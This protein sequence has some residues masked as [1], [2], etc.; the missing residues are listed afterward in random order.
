MDNPGI[1]AV[2]GFP[3]LRSARNITITRNNALGSISGLNSLQTANRI[4]ITQCRSLNSI[5]GFANLTSLVPAS[6]Q[7]PAALNITGNLALQTIPSFP[8]LSSLETISIMYNDALQQVTG[9]NSLRNGRSVY[10]GNNAALTT[11]SGFNGGV[12]LTS[13]ANITTNQLL[14]SITGFNG[15]RG[16]QECSVHHNP[17]LLDIAGFNNGAMTNAVV[18]TNNALTSVTGFR[19][20]D[21][22]GYIQVA[23]NPQLDTL[24]GFTGPRAPVGIYL[25]A[26]PRLYDFS[27]A[28]SF[29]SYSLLSNLTIQNNT[30]LAACAQP[31]ICAYLRRGGG[32]SISGNAPA[33]TQPAILQACQSHLVVSTGTAANPTVVPAGTYSSLTVT[34]TGYGVLAGDV[35]VSGPVVVQSGGGLSDGCHLL[36]GTGAFTLA[37]GGT[38]GICSPAGI[39]ASGATG[40]VQLTGI[41]SFSTDANY[42]YNG[43]TT[44]VTGSGL[45]GQVRSLSTTNANA[46][47]LTSP[48]AVSQIVGVGGAGNLVLNSNGL[49]LL[50]SGSGTALV[51]NSS[52]GVVSGTTATMQRHIETNTAGTG[53][54]HYSSPVQNESLGT[55]ATA[56]YAPNFSGAA[57]YNSSPT[58]GLVTP[59]PTV[60]QYDQ[61]RIATTAS[62]FSPFD[63]GYEAIASGSGA[64]EVG[65][66][67]AVNAPGAALVDFTGTL[68]TGNVTRSSLNR[69]GADG[70]WHL[71]GNPYPAPLDWSTLTLGAGQNLE[72]L[73]GAV[74]V[75]QSSGPYAGT[76][77]TY[78]AGAPGNGSPLIPAGAGF[79]VHTTAP[80]TPGT[81]RLTNANRVTAF[82]T[83]PAFGRG[84]ADARPQLAL[85][86]SN[87]ANTL[88]DE[89]TLYAEAR[90]TAGVEAA[91]DARKLANPSGLGL[92]LLTPA[93][94]AL[95]VDGRAALAAG[96]VVPL[97]VDVPAAG[98][99]TLRTTLANLPAGLTAYLRDATTGQQINLAAVPASSVQLAAGRSTRFSLVFGQQALATATALTPAQVQLS[100]N[101]AGPAAAVRVALPVAAGTGE[102]RAT[103]FNALGQQVGAAV[104]AVQSGEATGT[105]RTAGLAAGV[106][107]VRLQA[108]G[109][110]ISKRL[111][112]GQ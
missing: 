85:T 21:F 50:S 13:A 40:S 82:G 81:L 4:D 52:T 49:T 65:R 46:V 43:S 73:D 38:L 99:Y 110:V 107:V 108:G 100:P 29:T 17:S 67:Y 42:V 48:V 32:A 78:L 61:D 109:A 24:S 94:E 22:A 10:I 27:Q 75:F 8:S 56:G 112:V 19:N 36:T 83:Q 111:V 101:P 90:A 45:P 1:T 6:A 59:F 14:Q 15:M 71:L 64:M 11:I 34:S 102:V 62:D 92:A 12:S 26:N 5:G 25:T 103:V 88:A 44:Q 66:G 37:T 63:K 105:L 55:L 97:Q 89:A 7:E 69:T 30:L 80:G 9:F 2:S 106:Y 35:T 87:A 93:G 18:S 3:L 51:V 77:R 84:A 98:A 53:Y 33:C 86:L 95:A 70:G 72:N 41:R 31:W 28:F 79:F 74:Y 60:F 20:S 68:T 16:A 54:R 96:T 76:Y 58:P 57:A 47:T 91:F 39:T 23:S 104:L